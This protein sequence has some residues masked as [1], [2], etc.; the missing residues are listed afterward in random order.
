MV[1][2][3][4]PRER[5]KIIWKRFDTNFTHERISSELLLDLTTVGKY[6]KIFKATGDVLTQLEIEMEEAEQRSRGKRG[7]GRYPAMPQAHLEALVEATDLRPYLYLEEYAEELS[8]RGLF[9]RA[10]GVQYS[11]SC[12]C[13]AL[14]RLGLTRKKLSFQSHRVCELERQMYCDGIKCF[15][16]EQLVFLDET[17]RDQKS[18]RRRTGRAPSGVTPVCLTVPGTGKS[19]SILALTGIAGFLG[20]HTI[21]GG[22]DAQSFLAAFE[23]RILPFLRP[24]PE[25]QSVLVLDNCAIHH[26]VRDELVRLV[27]ARGARIFW[28][29]AYSPSFNPIE[30]LFAQLKAWFRHHFHWCCLDPARA[31][32]VGMARAVSIRVAVAQYEHSGYRCSPEAAAELAP[33]VRD[34]TSFLY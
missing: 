10:P 7:G 28:L 27:E 32:E 33:F 22:Y 19:H 34:D 26:A 21:E 4:S 6:I 18:M 2:A 17:R 14:F 1:A 25:P 13:K 12:I 29:P 30:A 20:W 31:I 3:L 9:A 16:A 23:A 5:W 8:Y 24:F 11:K 15:F